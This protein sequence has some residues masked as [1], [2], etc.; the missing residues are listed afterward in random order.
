M[1]FT[2][3]LIAA[4]VAT[5]ASAAPSS[6]DKDFATKAAQAG[7]AEIAAPYFRSM[8]IDRP[9]HIVMYQDPRDGT[10]AFHRRHRRR[11]GDI[12]VISTTDPLAAGVKIMR[13]LKAGAVVALRADRTLAGKGVPVT[14]LG[15]RVLLPA[16]PFVAAALS[17]AP[18]VYVYTCRVGHRAYRCTISPAP[19]PA[20]A[21]RR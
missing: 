4:T 16:G 15:D 19:A 13:A 5:A 11:L 6:M 21:T 10:E 20:A 8:G 7:M 18:V 9:V 2:F 1:K 3:A 14:L 12:P 17:G